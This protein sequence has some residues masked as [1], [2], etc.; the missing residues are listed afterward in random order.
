[1]RSTIPAR[2]KPGVDLL[3][4]ADRRHEGV[5]RAPVFA[6]VSYARRLEPIAETAFVN[7]S[8]T[9]NLCTAYEGCKFFFC[10][11]RLWSLQALSGDC[12]T[13]HDDEVLL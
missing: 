6:A 1:M 3:W 9:D 13:G 12:W 11:D 8:A 5:D 2:P 10:S 7:T 4:G